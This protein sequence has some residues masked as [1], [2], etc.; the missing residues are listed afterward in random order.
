MTLV[1]TAA[2]A[3]SSSGAMAQVAAGVLSASQASI[4]VGSIPATGNA[5]LI[6][7]N[8]RTDAAAVQTDNVNVRFNGSSSAVYTWAQL[9]GGT[10]GGSNVGSTDTKWV[11]KATGATADADHFASNVIEIP[12][13]A[14]AAHFKYGVGSLFESRLLSGNQFAYAFGGGFDSI[15]AIAS[16]ALTPTTGTVFV[17]GSSY[18]VYIVT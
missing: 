11:I 2:K 3:G 16:V 12:N 13:Y 9:F 18:A 15:A 14:N 5:L 4:S 17:A 8:L 1:A 10:S 6:Y 7:A